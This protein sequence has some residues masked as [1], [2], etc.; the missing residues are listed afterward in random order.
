MSVG[1]A[2]AAMGARPE[3]RDDDAATPRQSV[4]RR[5]RH[6]L[7]VAR[8]ARRRTRQGEGTRGR[9]NKQTDRQT[10]RRRAGVP[11]RE[12][13]AARRRSGGEA[14][15]GVPASRRGF[16][17]KAEAKRRDAATR[18]HRRPL[19]V[20]RSCV[21]AVRVS[22]ALSQLE[23]KSESNL[24]WLSA[25]AVR[26]RVRW[27]RP[28]V[29][30]AGRRPFLLSC[31]AKWKRMSEFSHRLPHATLANKIQ[32][33]NFSKIWNLEVCSL[34]KRSDQS[35]ECNVINFPKFGPF[36]LLKISFGRKD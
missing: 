34:L 22:P 23:G 31:H 35:I 5:R 15:R 27:H 2:M 11:L 17:G 16:G 14:P 25:G 30:P 29:G 4:M 26:T 6:G 9:T 8:G 32:S 1:C 18:E 19:V 10:G 24:I 7:H 21:R 20:H 13:P 12:K 36:C 33:Q 28:G 3:H